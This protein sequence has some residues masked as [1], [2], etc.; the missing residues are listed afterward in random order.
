MA[1][2]IRDEQVPLN[3]ANL[4][5]K[6]PFGGYKQSGNGGEWGVE[7]MEEYLE[8]KAMMGGAQFA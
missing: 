6:A 1:R 4:D 8:A 2:R 5:F 3:G 7:G